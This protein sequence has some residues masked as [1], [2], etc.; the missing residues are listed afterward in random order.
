MRMWRIRRVNPTAYD[1]KFH[2]DENGH[3]YY[4]RGKDRGPSFWVDADHVQK[5]LSQLK[6]ARGYD[7][8]THTYHT[9][10]YEAVEVEVTEVTSEN[11]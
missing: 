9:A 7:Y 5:A 4:Q 10:E 11:T 3:I 2:A 1:L 6:N 8:D